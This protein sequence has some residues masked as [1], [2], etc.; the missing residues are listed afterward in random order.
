[1]RF[2]RS[3]C[4]FEHNYRGNE[5]LQQ[6]GIS[7]NM[8]VVDA[9]F[10]PLQQLI[11]YYQSSKEHQ[12]QPKDG[13]LLIHVNILNIPIRNL[14][15][16]VQ[17]PIGK[18][19]AYYFDSADISHSDPGGSNHPLV[20]ESIEEYF[21]EMVVLDAKYRPTIPF[22]WY[23]RGFFPIKRENT[24]LLSHNEPGGASYL[25]PN[26][27]DL[28]ISSFPIFYLPRFN[29]FTVHEELEI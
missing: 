19:R 1:M 27:E 9:G 7:I 16:Y 13:N 8:A 5:H 12:F 14:P 15:Y 2:A 25:C 3:H 26:S 24:D 10:F 20:G 6:F 4:S 22:L 17:I 28:F 23:R 18:I 21:T 11:Q 29:N